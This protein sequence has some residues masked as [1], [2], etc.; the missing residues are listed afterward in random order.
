MSNTLKTRKYNFTAIQQT[1]GGNIFLQRDCNSFAI[2][3]IGDT[4]A[5]LNGVP[6]FPSSAP[7]TI[8]GDTFELNGEELESYEGNL[9]LKFNAPLG[10]NPKVV[11][12]QQ[13]YTENLK[14]F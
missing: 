7:A 14:S 6:V 1:K 11:I 2:I 13:Y 12:L 10:A 9:T 5:F 4:L 8:R 3:N